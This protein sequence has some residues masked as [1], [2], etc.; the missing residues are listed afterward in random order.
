MNNFTQSF[1]L[2]VFSRFLKIRNYSTQDQTDTTRYGVKRY[3]MESWLEN[4]QR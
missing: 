2:F 1:F 4:N 3:M